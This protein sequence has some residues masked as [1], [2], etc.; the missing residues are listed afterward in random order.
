ML[1]N[2]FKRIPYSKSLLFKGLPPV[3]P[4]VIREA[5]VEYGPIA[6]GNDCIGAII[7]KN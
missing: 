5:L 7:S 6:S 4:D 3:A 2:S 1:A